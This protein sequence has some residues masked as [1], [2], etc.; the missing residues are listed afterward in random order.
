MIGLSDSNVA[1]V[2]K[3]D[4]I[5]MAAQDCAVTFR[6]AIAVRSANAMFILS[7]VRIGVRCGMCGTLVQESVRQ[8]VSATK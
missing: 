2:L 4:G 5:V 1:D 7:A 3:D 6:S 8:V